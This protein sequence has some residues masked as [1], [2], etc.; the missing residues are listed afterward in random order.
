[1][2]PPYL[3]LATKNWDTVFFSFALGLLGVFLLGG[4][5]PPGARALLEGDRLTRQGKYAA[6]IEKLKSATQL[7]PEE[8][9]ARAWNHLGLAY[10]RAGQWPD[11]ITAYQQALKRNP[12][13]AV[14]RFNLGCLF[15]EQNKLPEAVSEFTT[16]T[17]LE[18]NGLDA[19]IKLGT[20]QLRF[21]QWDAAE[22]SFTNALQLNAGSVEALNGLGVLQLQ[23]KSLPKAF[24]Y[25]NSALQRQPSYPPA[26]LN[27]AILHHQYLTN[28]PLALQRYHAYLETKPPP[29]SAAAV[30]QIVRQIEL[31]LNPPP[32]SAATNPPVAAPAVV[33][34]PTPTPTTNR[35]VTQ[36]SPPSVPPFVSTLQS[37]QITAIPM[38][39]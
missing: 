12:N 35:P 26:L 2:L 29:A 24:N 14:A 34:A 5:T 21:R 28:R 19:L 20:A 9:Q 30:Q 18:K 7:L 25:F 36:A 33:Q 4:C 37:N 31:E 32:Q 6:A 3:M 17:L 16:C 27:L 22:K 23:R 11:A 38:L 8:S 1:M 15:L 13:L 39:K 10:H